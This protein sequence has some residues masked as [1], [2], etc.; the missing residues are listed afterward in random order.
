MADDLKVALTATLS[1]SAIKI[2]DGVADHVYTVLSI[3]FCE[4]AGADELLGIALGANA[5]SDGVLLRGVVNVTGV[6]NL[7]N[8]GRALYIS[9]TAGDVT[10]T[11]P[12]GNNEIVRIVGYV[13]HADDIMYFNPDSTWVKVTA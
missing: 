4:T 11:A 5:L 9:T 7:T 12:S 8:V 6:S 10:E 2:L 13:L 3:S 1:N